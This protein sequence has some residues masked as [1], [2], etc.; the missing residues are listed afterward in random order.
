MRFFTLRADDSLTEVHN[1]SEWYKVTNIVLD[2][3]SIPA[4]AEN[5]DSWSV[6]VYKMDG[7]PDA[8]IANLSRTLSQVEV[9]LEFSINDHVRFVLQSNNNGSVGVAYLNG[10]EIYK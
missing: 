2:L 5:S 7:S 9:D 10:Y 8:L 3:Q 6:W 1:V 4:N